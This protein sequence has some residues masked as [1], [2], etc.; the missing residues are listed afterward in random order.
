MNRSSL[1]GER[2]HIS[3]Q[4]VCWKPGGLKSAQLVFWRWEGRA[5]GRAAAPQKDSTWKDT[6]GNLEGVGEP[7]P[8]WSESPACFSVIC[9]GR[10]WAPV[11]WHFSLYSG[12]REWA[13]GWSGEG[14][15]GLDPHSLCR[16]ARTVVNLSWADSQRCQVSR[17]PG[18]Q[19][20]C[21]H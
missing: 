7:G 21:R 3:F 18:R 6:G 12:N 10:G 19:G 16:R 2:K 8:L 14:R 20:L 9:R 5:V 1:A 13:R 11:S 4:A 17:S 15:R